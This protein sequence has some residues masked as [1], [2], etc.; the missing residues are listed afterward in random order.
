MSSGETI[1]RMVFMYSSWSSTTSP[2]FGSFFMSDTDACE[3]VFID[4]ALS[5]LAF[6]D[7][8]VFFNLD[9]G[10]GHVH[11][12]NVLCSAQVIADFELGIERS[13]L[14]KPGFVVVFLNLRENALGASL[15]PVPGFTH[16]R[17]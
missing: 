15:V 12:A 9:F 10:A 5:K 3:F 4:L 17:Q 7:G 6:N 8:D 16:L 13:P 2:V 14:F 1:G 11:I